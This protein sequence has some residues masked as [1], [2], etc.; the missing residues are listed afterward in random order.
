[1]EFNKGDLVCVAGHKQGKGIIVHCGGR[2]IFYDVFWFS[3]GK[4]VRGYVSS[5]LRRL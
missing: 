4:V 5:E 2:G 1:M 3:I